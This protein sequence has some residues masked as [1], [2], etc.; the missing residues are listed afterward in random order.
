MA[1]INAKTVKKLLETVK[2]QLGRD[3]TPKELGRL[4]NGDN[5]VLSKKVKVEKS[6]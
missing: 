5:S 4:L 3:L 2:R 1:A 6:K